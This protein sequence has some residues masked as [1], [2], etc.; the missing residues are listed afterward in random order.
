MWLTSGKHFFVFI[1]YNRSDVDNFSF[2]LFRRGKRP[3][4]F[5]EYVRD[6]KDLM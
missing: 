4:G 3:F 2:T 6:H 1:L 5:D